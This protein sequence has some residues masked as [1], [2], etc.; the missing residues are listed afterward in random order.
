VYRREQALATAPSKSSGV[1]VCVCVCVLCVCVSLSLSLSLCQISAL[2]RHGTA[3]WWGRKRGGEVV[4]EELVER[5]KAPHTSH[6]HIHT[7]THTWDSQ[8]T[9]PLCLASIFL[10]PPP[11]SPPSSPPSPLSPTCVRKCRTV[12]PGAAATAMA[13]AAY[14]GSPSA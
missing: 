9:F 3:S 6:T 5:E 10:L 1:C 7:H 8:L 12:T 11:L 4:K 2:T 14:T 13:T